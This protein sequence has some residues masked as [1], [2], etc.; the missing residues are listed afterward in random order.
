MNT[1]FHSN[2]KLLLTGEYVILDGA[3]GLAIPTKFGQSMEVYEGKNNAISWRSINEQGKTWFEEN[4]L[5]AANGK[6]KR[7]KENPVSERLEQILSVANSM[8]PDLLSGKTG[9]EITS[10]L[11]FPQNWGLGSSSTLINNIAAWFEIDAYKLLEATFGG[12]GYDL[13]CA[14]INQPLIYRLQE[15]KRLVTKENFNPP[16]QDKLFFV[17]LNQK[18][19]SRDAI[20]HYKNQ[21]K[22]E[23]SEAI[24][25]ITQ[26]TDTVIDCED[27][28]SFQKL[29]N[30]HEKIISSLIKIPPI[31]AQLFSDYPNTI[32]SLGG[33]GGDFIMAI[34]EEE[35]KN[36]FRKKGFQTVVAYS[37]MTL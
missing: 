1:S 31:K 26:I 8:N 14:K 34:G 11:D 28:I 24:K 35:D 3:K 22:D 4:F 6:I 29:L 19:N 25:A 37:E 21:P 33:W 17:H 32:K 10:T 5:I 7:S 36:Y 9:F 23:L 12:S 20:A 13:A 15:E 27:I 2:G 30:E 18:K 16:F